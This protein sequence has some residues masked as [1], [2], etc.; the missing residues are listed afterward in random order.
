MLGTA[1]C[2]QSRRTHHI[3]YMRVQRGV[4][5][6]MRQEPHV[7]GLLGLHEGIFVALGVP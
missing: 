1:Y 5:G 3:K 2:A 7:R 6:G 4:G